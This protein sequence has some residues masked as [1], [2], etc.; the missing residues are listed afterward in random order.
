VHA[1]RP[2]IGCHFEVNPASRNG[3]GTLNH[4]LFNVYNKLE[5]NK[6]TREHLFT[7]GKREETTGGG[8]K[9]CDNRTPKSLRF[10][11][12]TIPGEYLPHMCIY[13][14]SRADQERFSP[15]QSVRIMN[16]LGRGCLLDNPDNNNYSD[17]A[18]GI[19]IENIDV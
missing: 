17:E 9:K 11:E 15:P 16:C 14:T 10:D 6:I 5:T 8:I 12:K 4:Y 7:C 13:S 1:E 18:L 3:G 19:P 2:Q